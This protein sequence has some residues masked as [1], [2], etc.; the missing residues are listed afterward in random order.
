MD[1]AVVMHNP[2]DQFS[3]I[4]QNP[5][6]RQNYA[7]TEQTF[8]PQEVCKA[9]FK[10]T[11]KGGQHNRQQATGNRQQATGNYTHYQINRVN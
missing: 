7:H 9:N 10:L 4:G 1:A 3:Q 11:A 8:T 5:T 2:L 6:M